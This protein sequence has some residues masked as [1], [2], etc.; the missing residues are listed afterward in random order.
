MATTSFTALRRLAGIAFTL[1]LFSLCLT[2]AAIGQTPLVTA[3]APVGL[4]HP[5]GWGQTASET[6][7]QTAIDMNGDWLVAPYAP[8]GGLFEFPA[9]GGAMVTLVPITGLGNNYQNPLILVDPANNIYVG[10]NWNNC[11]LEYPYDVTTNSWPTLLAGSVALTASNPSPNECGVYPPTIAQY[12][13]FGFSPYYFQP[14]GAAIGNANTGAASGNIVVGNQNSGNWIFDMTVQGAWSNPTVTQSSS[15]TF[16]ILTAMTTRP[17]SIAVDPEGNIYFVE[18]PGGL[19]GVYEIPQSFVAAGEAQ[20]SAGVGGL[21][22]GAG[23]TDTSPG[24]VRVDPM[25]PDVTGVVTDAQGNLYVSDADDGVFMIPNPSGTPE[26]SQTV[27]LSPLPTQGEVAVDPA[28]KILYV[29]TTQTQNNGQADVAKVWVGYAEFGSSNVGKTTSTP[30]TID[31]NFSGAATPGSFVIV[32]D[33]MTTPEFAISSGNCATGTAYGPSTLPFCTENVSFTPAGVGSAS[34][35]LLMLDANN[36][37]LASMNLHGTGVGANAQVLAGIEST[38]GTTLDTPT[39]V[40]TDASANVYVA[41]PGLGKVVE[42]AA[43]SSSAVAVNTGSVT[44]VSPTGVAVDGTGDVF[45]ADS[46][47]SGGGAVYEVPFGPNGLNSTGIVTLASGLGTS[48]LNLAADGLGDLYV[49]DPTNARVI[50][51]SG[52]GDSGAGALGVS[53]TILTTGF[54]APSAVAVDSNNNLYIVDGSNLFELAGGVSAPISSST[55]TTV[56]TTVLNN[57]SGATGISVDPSG[58][59]YIASTSGVTRIPVVSGVAGSGTAIVTASSSSVALD[60]LGNVYATPPSGSG[61][62]LVSTVGTLA[63]PTPSSLTSPTSATTTITNIGN[64]PLT[65]SGYTNST[66]VV[67]SVTIAD[68]TGADGSCVDD[69]TAPATGIPAGGTCQVVVTFNP[70]P[71]EQ[72]ALTGWVEA[73]SNAINA[74]ITIDT[75]GTALAL[76]TSNTG[77]TVGTSQVV[78]TPVTVTVTPSS[79]TVTPTGTVQ[80]SYTSW[81]VVVPT[82]CATP[83]CAPTIN[84]VT[85]TASSA[86]TNGQAQFTLAPVLA[87]SQTITVGYS[88]DRTYGRSTGTQTATVAKSSI[89]GFIADPKAPSYLP[90]VQ[91]QSGSTPYDGSQ[92]YWQ[93]NMPVTVNTAA[94]IPTGTVTFMDNTSSCPSGTSATGLGAGMCAGLLGASGVACPLNVGQGVQ[95]VV[96]SGTPSANAGGTATFVSSCLAMPTFVTYTPVVSTHYITPVYSGDANF[97]GA[98]DPVSSVFQVLRSS[99][100]NITTT[101]PST[102]ATGPVYTAITPTSLSVQPGSTASLTL[103]L[104]PLLG[105]G[106]EGKGAE[107]NNYNFPVSL[108]CDNLPPHTECTFTYPT[109]VSAYQPSAPNSAQICPQPT[110]DSNSDSNTAFEALAESGGCNASGVGVVTMT[111]NTDVSAGTTTSQNGTAASVTLASIFGLGMIGLFFRR[112]AFQ[113]GRWLLMVVLMIVGGTLAVTLTACNTT[114]LTPLAQLSTPAGSYT[115]NITAV[116]V[117]TQCV[118]QTGPGANCTTPSGGTG[119]L[120]YGSNNQ[121]SLPYYIN[122]TVQ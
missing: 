69:S 27:M 22:G 29:P 72:G 11:M 47:A 14:W 38:I 99:M 57:L 1:I 17:D 95:Y 43:G 3:S 80:V 97:L 16:G 104:A 67:D 106:F 91:E 60:R 83:P 90:F 103:Y 87:G 63:L 18:D 46:G 86:L 107:L 75:S 94:G 74:P 81:T 31:F 78:N 21:N 35:K 114:N 64:A 53:E 113:K 85:A 122:L 20:G 40:T 118:P 58:A 45:I 24:I 101:M 121:V 36:N 68:F 61:I 12:S 28:R 51:I 32:E 2:G 8:N 55:P 42:F 56:P 65:I 115:V 70:G 23:V 112:R 10:G 84:P 111:I 62:T 50:R 37:I 105:Y 100:V 13:I 82:S 34:A 77:V 48:G 96:N 76:S 116:Q 39:Q 73:T 19:P 6:I 93:Y 54:T 30:M 25:L 120:V 79:G 110:L 88:G 15:S 9:N 26:T 102:P 119:V 108:Q 49:A 33:G 59:V 66:S 117:G 52:L 7:N 5:A 109:S 41:D 89:V 98:T 44:L 71:G 92:Q 4:N